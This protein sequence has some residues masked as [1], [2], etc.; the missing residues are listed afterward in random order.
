[1]CSQTRRTVRGRRRLRFAGVG[2]DW[3]PARPRAGVDP[4]ALRA[5]IATHSRLVRRYAGIHDDGTPDRDGS[6]DRAEA[7]QALLGDVDAELVAALDIAVEADGTWPSFRVSVIGRNRLFP[8]EWRAGA[9]GTLLPT[10]ATD[11]VTRWR[12]WYSQVTAGQVRHYLRRLDIWDTA[13][14]LHDTQAELVA[15][16][17]RTLGRTNAWSRKERFLT[18]RDQV[19]H[20]PA[21]PPAVPPG[22]PPLTT[23]PPPTNTTAPRRWLPTSPGSPTPPAPSTAPCR[24]ASNA[25]FPSGCAASTSRSATRGWKNSSSGSTPLCSRDTAST[26]GR[27]PFT[28]PA[29]W[30]SVNVPASSTQTRMVCPPNIPSSSK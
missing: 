13:H 10:D 6:D 20:L 7:G 18:A 14:E 26:S 25:V 15:T 23:H 8:P 19:L 28:Y 21:P 9:W 22:P 27:D 29:I 5:L 2:T 24:P 16:A 30:A 3:A 4:D 17:Q 1:M 12:R 11:A